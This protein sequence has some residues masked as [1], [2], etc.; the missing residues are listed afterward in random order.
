M[1]NQLHVGTKADLSFN[2]RYFWPM[3]SLGLPR[4]LKKLIVFF[5]I[6]DAIQFLN[7]FKSSPIIIKYLMHY[8]IA[9]LKGF[10]DSFIIF[11]SFDTVEVNFYY[12]NLLCLLET[13]IFIKI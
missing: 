13:K 12:Q 7:S 11:S 8:E 9:F 6:S 3:K 5:K 10:N 4:F 1:K 2:L